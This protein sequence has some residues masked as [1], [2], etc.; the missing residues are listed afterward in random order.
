MKTSLF[1][2]DF[3][4]QAQRRIFSFLPVRLRG[5]LAAAL[6]CSR[7]SPH[8][9]CRRSYSANVWLSVWKCWWRSD[10][11]KRSELYEQKDWKIVFYS[12]SEAGVFKG[13]HCGPSLR[14]NQCPL[15]YRQ[16]SMNYFNGENTKTGWF[17]GNS[18]ALFFSFIASLS[19]LVWLWIE[20]SHY[21]RIHLMIFPFTSPLCCHS[22]THAF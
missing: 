2:G 13:G 8:S 20:W 11:E 12:S 5:R 4:V 6:Q 18:G 19:V 22:D 10:E 17:L 15:M 21:T 16:L 7:P 14:P 9:R 1:K 3:S